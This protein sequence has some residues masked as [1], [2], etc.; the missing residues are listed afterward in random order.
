MWR[1]TGCGISIILQRWKPDPVPVNRADLDTPAHA[2]VILTLARLHESKALDV[3]LD[4]LPDLPG[5]Y[6]WMAGE[7]PLRGVLEQMAQDNGVADRVRFLGWRSDRAGLLEAADICV[8]CSRYEPFGT[9]FVQAWGAA[10]AGDCVGCGRGPRQFVRD[11][12]DGLMVPRDDADAL[13]QAVRRLLEDE[14]LQDQLTT[15]GYQRY[16]NEF[17]KEKTVESYL[18]FYYDI[19]QREGA[20]GRVWRLLFNAPVFTSF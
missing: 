7:G 14:V 19:L 17:T 3:L 10:Y 8:F 12:E 15:R 20:G 18:G 1:L 13:V 4:A 5:V 9:V 2:P 6:V 16:R 11:G